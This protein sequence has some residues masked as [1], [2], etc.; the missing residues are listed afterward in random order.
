MMEIVCTFL[1]SMKPCDGDIAVSLDL[2][3]LKCLKGSSI[4]CVFIEKRKRKQTEAL[5]A[6]F[7]HCL[8]TDPNSIICSP[9]QVHT[10]ML[11]F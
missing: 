7:I 11:M 5:F 8:A 4:G 3:C 1:F 10:P 6:L 2:I 9:T